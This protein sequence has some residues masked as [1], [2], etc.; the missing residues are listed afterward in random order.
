[1]DQERK[2]GLY[3]LVLGIIVFLLLG[4]ALENASPRPAQDFKL[5]Y[6]GTRCLMRQCD[7]YNPTDLIRF[8]ASEHAI[9]RDDNAITRET[10]AQYLY[11]PTAGSVIMPFALLPFGVARLLWLLL[12][13]GSLTIACYLMWEVG[14]ESAP[15][16]SGALL[17]F[18]AANCALFMAV[19]NP[20]SVAIGLC[21][22][23]SWCFV[24][25]R[26]EVTGAVCMAISLILK[27]H[28]GALI[29]FYFLCAGGS[30]R[31]RALQ[32]F[33]IAAGLSLPAL[34]WAGHVAPHWASELNANLA[35]NSAPGGL[36][37][38]GPSS[39]AAHGIGMVISLQALLSLCRDHPAFYNPASYLICGGILAPWLLISL[40]SRASEA[41][42]WFALAPISA[43]SLLPIYHRLGD[44]K[45]L[46]LALPAC[47]ALY[48]QGGRTG[49]LALWLTA[50]AFFLT[51]DFSWLVTLEVI[52]HIST[53]G[54]PSLQAAF[55]GLQ[56]I[57]VPAVLLVLGVFFLYVYGVQTRHPRLRNSRIS[58]CRN[59]VSE[60]ID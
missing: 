46:L 41:S 8:Y 52:R 1:M 21:V 13:F 32:T 29:W 24:R 56:V 17:G 49:K 28:D 54:K 45:L 16:V 19:G 37:D 43:L 18:S 6:Y 10:E 27:P 5:V 57:P 20:G 31:K 25:N 11:P 50:I 4:T 58:T 36:S 23:A 26:F 40:R 12:L 22:I 42:A 51:A 39:K 44:A 55:V 34:L 48:A 53:A 3:L 35:A 9:S 47:A 38:P 15:T 59:D 14:A 7:P 60:S 33:C 30:Y 2:D